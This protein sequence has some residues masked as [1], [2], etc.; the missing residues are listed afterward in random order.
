MFNI[1]FAIDRNKMSN[2]KK[3]G[4]GT[5]G[6]EEKKGG[7]GGLRKKGGGRGAWVEIFSNGG[8]NTR[9]RASESCIISLEL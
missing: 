9:N 6:K 7:G 5:G 2:K 1:H 4:G 8:S 3:G